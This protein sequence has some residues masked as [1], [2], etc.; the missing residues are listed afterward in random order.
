MIINE[1]QKHPKTF[2]T[3]PPSTGLSKSKAHRLPIDFGTAEVGDI[4]LS[5]VEGRPAIRIH[6]SLGAKKLMLENADN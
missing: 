2:P 6:R 3:F 1:F 4:F 5:F